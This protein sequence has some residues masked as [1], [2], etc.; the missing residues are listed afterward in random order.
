MMSHAPECQGYDPRTLR[1]N[2]LL[3]VQ[4]TGLFKLTTYS[5]SYM[6]SRI[7]M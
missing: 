5:K 4:D 3:M 6:E 7:V 2:V 1:L